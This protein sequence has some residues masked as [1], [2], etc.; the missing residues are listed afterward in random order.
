MFREKIKIPVV[1]ETVI[2]F[3]AAVAAWRNLMPK[4]YW[5]IKY[6]VFIY[7]TF[8]VKYCENQ[9]LTINHGWTV[10]R[11]TT[12]IN[13]TYIAEINYIHKVIHSNIQ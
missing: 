8:L 4:I 12:I 6:N 5:F 10:Q 7:E 2:V 3:L 1:S 13:F 11:K 9:N